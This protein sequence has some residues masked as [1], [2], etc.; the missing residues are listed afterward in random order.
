MRKELHKALSD[1]IPSINKRVFPL[2]M[3]QD[4]KKNSIVYKVVANLDT[5]G[6]TCTN[7]IN[8]RYSVQLDIYA[9]TYEESVTLLKEASQ[10]LRDNFLIFNLTSFESWENITLRYRQIVDFQIELKQK[11]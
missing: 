5:T 11:F 9:K 4:M 7:P 1:N 6:I 2:K 10:T 3:P 8:T